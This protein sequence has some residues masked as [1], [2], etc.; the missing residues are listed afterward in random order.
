MKGMPIVRRYSKV[1]SPRKIFLY[2]A[3]FQIKN[4]IYLTKKWKIYNLHKLKYYRFF[5]KILISE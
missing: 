2:F 1:A 5:S 3:Y 4:I